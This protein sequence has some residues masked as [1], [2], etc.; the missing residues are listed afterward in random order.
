MA[1][2]SS[3]GAD[4]FRNAVSSLRGSKNL[5][6]RSVSEYVQDNL[7]YQSGTLLFLF[8]KSLILILIFNRCGF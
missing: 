8:N 3:F 1:G 5:N 6:G 7:I 4:V 2:K